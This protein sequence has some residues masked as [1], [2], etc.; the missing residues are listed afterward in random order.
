MNVVL[1]LGFCTNL[2]NRLITNDNF[3]LKC[4]YC[5]IEEFNPG[6]GSEEHAILSALGGRRR[7]ISVVKPVTI[8]L[9]GK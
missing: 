3:M 2:K 7:E 5:N 8:N 1:F 6:E 9:G 4:L